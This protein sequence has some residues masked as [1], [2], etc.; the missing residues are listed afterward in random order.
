MNHVPKILVVDDMFTIRAFVK[1]LLRP[2]GWRLLEA[3]DGQ[4]ALTMC[5]RELPDVVISDVRMA[6]MGG[7]ELCQKLKAS[8]PCADIPV[9]FLTSESDTDSRTR[10]LAAGAAA[11]LRKPINAEEL[12]RT[13]K[14]LVAGSFRPAAEHA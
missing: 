11:F 9:V 7:I 2:F 12:E 5:L 4:E 14:Q 8:P 10:G 1:G 13:L 3:G 6:G